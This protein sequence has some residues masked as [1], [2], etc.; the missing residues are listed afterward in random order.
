VRPLF[1]L[2]LC[3]LLSLPCEARAM[4]PQE[5]LADFDQM[6]GI[7]KSYYSM[8]HY[9]KEVMGID[10]ASQV[11]DFRQKVAAVT[12]DNAFYDLL[13]GFIASFKDAH[14]NHIRPSSMGAELGFTT[15]RVGAKA[16]VMTIDREILP[17]ANFPFK[18]GDE[19][20]SLDGKPVEEILKAGLPLCSNGREESALGLLTRRLTWRSG[21]MG[22]VPTGMCTVAIRHSGK[23]A[24]DSMVMPWI[25]KGKP[26][27]GLSFHLGG[28]DWSGLPLK[29]GQLD[30]AVSLIVDA[31]PAEGDTLPPWAP[32]D[33]QAVPSKVFPAALFDS[34]KGLLGYVR[35]P[36]FVPSDPVAAVNEFRR[37]L[38]Q[39]KLTRGLILDLNDNP[40]GNVY[41]SFELAAMLSDKV[42][43]LPKKAE[44]ANLTNLASY[45]RM[46]SYTKDPAQRAMLEFHE[47]EI[48]KALAA[49]Q[50]M[51]APNYLLGAPSQAPDPK[52]TYTKPILLLINDQCYSCGDLFPAVLKD[53]QRVTLF[54]TNTAGA[55]GSI[56]MMGPLSYCGSQISCT[57]N[58]TQRSNG[59][60]IENVGIAPDVVCAWTPEDVVSG[61]KAYRKAYTAALAALIK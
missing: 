3:A 25:T 34:P 28:G 55:G 27:P 52:L 35:I 33:A 22:A 50:D 6:V 8:I 54:G 36:D 32:D 21:R 20:L 49:G 45:R 2:I 47:K 58:L 44:R 29:V 10:F 16:L 51:T 53:N 7:L 30:P 14:T 13:S 38:T 40:G 57:I 56:G 60:Y 31:G 12:D 9:K 41:Y 26:L 39:M 17:V 5:R 46:L 24:A 11:T 37:V 23:E 59:S 19:L 15:R 61:F 4:T 42:L 43:A 18:A 48:E 1:C